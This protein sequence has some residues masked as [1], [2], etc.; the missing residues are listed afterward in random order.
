MEVTFST[1]DAATCARHPCLYYP[2]IANIYHPEG[3]SAC[4]D[5]RSQVILCKL[6]TSRHH[7]KLLGQC[8][9]TLL[10]SSSDAFLPRYMTSDDIPRIVTAGSLPKS[11]AAIQAKSPDI[12]R[13]LY[14]LGL[15]FDLSV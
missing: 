12:R 4:R 9:H 13:N 2:L 8:Y 6:C 14:V 7:L 5:T 15:P 3:V 11:R 1:P 10:R